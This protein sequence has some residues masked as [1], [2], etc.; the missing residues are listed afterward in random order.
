MAR[1]V[2]DATAALFGDLHDW[3]AST[4]EEAKQRFGESQFTRLVEEGYLRYGRT[5]HGIPFVA[6]GSEGRRILNLRPFTYKMTPDAA[7][8]HLKRREARKLLE[9]QHYTFEGVHD[10]TLFTFR[11]PDSTLAYLAVSS[12][13]GSTGFSVRNV[14]RL[15]ARYAPLLQNGNKLI[16]GTS[17]PHRL[18]RQVER[19]KETLVVLPLSVTKLKLA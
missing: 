12:H 11:A 18:K 14:N 4:I 5:T 17:A 2:D 8:V 10:R 7:S 16:I 19:N 13:T 15:L 9:A 6:L 1:G 3:G